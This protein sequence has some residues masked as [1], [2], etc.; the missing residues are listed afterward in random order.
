MTKGQDP[1]HLVAVGCEFAIGSD[2]SK[3]WIKRSDFPAEVRNS[4][5]AD[6][7][8]WVAS[9][10]QLYGS[11]HVKAWQIFREAKSG[12]V[13][14][15]NK[16]RFRPTKRDG[17]YIPFYGPDLQRKHYDTRND[18]RDTIKTENFKVLSLI[19]HGS[20]DSPLTCIRSSCG[21]RLVGHTD[22]GMRIRGI[23]GDLHHI[24]VW[25]NKSLAKADK[26]PSK[27]LE[28]CDLFN[29]SNLASQE[30]VNELKQCA[31]FCDNCHGRRHK[32]MYDRNPDTAHGDFSDYLEEGDI[33][34][35]LQSQENY[36]FVD[37]E[38]QTLG[39][40]PA[41]PMCDALARLFL[42]ENLKLL[43]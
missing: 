5:P 19:Y 22:L 37:T 34:F 25:E 7:K 14:Q 20:F 18:R 32:A 1:S 2:G 40:P 39:Y 43:I 21:N 30:V 10:R 16:F 12:G 3:Y 23:D 13:Y 36:D 17:R 9:Q 29:G 28:S 35:Y 24:L 42:P 15:L 31:P 41:E 26:D 33:P 4:N 27:L 8:E 38:L 6:I 11:D